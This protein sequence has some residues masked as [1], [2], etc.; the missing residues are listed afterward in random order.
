MYSTQV[1]ELE[2]KKGSASSLK[3]HLARKGQHRLLKGG[4]GILRLQINDKD[5]AN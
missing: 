1:L 5:I 3:G 2:W 4:G